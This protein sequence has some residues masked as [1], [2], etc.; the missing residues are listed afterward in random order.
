MEEEYRKQYE[1]GFANGVNAVR[2]KES[3]IISDHNSLMAERL[4]GIKHKIEVDNGH[5]CYD[6][7]CE[8]CDK[9]VYNQAIDD[10]I[11]LID[12]LKEGGK[13]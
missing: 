11:A 2:E 8:Y 4:R 12:S 1:L 13:E 3:K 5:D 7:H 6:L 9:M 10:A